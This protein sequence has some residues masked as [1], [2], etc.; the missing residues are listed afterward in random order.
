MVNQFEFSE[1]YISVGFFPGYGIPE[2]GYF[3][4]PAEDLYS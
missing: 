1:E 4:R 3:Y 2:N